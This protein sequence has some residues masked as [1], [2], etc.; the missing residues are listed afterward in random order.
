MLLCALLALVGLGI[1]VAMA[2]VM[3]E[4][5]YIVSKKQRDR[6]G[7]FGPAGAFAQAY[8]LFNCSWATGSLLGPLYA[9]F[10]QQRAGWAT[11]AWCLA[12]LP[13]VSAIVAVSPPGYLRMGE[14][15]GVGE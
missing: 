7:Q 2:P 9:G 8:A 13:A 5:T 14:K 11:M 4:V 1:E 10:I 12:L 6:P 3:A 15:Y